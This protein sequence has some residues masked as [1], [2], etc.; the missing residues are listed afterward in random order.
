MSDE[1]AGE[2]DDA[3]ARVCDGGLSEPQR[4]ALMA[5]LR[6]SK[7]ARE[8]YIRHVSLHFWLRAILHREEDA[9]DEQAGGVASTRATEGGGWFHATW[10]ASVTAA[11]AIGASLLLLGL[12][13]RR[14]GSRVPPPIAGIVVGGVDCRWSS[15]DRLAVG[16]TIRSGDLISLESGTVSLLF[17]SRTRVVAPGPVSFRVVSATECDLRHGELVARVLKGG[18]GFRVTAGTL[19]VIDRG[20]AFGV[21]RVS[22]ADVEVE[23]FEGEV[24]L[25]D[26][27]VASAADIGDEAPLLR[28]GQTA[29]VTLGTHATTQVIRVG[30]GLSAAF[31]TAVG[32]ESEAEGGQRVD[33]IFEGFSQAGPE[34]RIDKAVGGAGWTTPW[35]DSHE[36]TDTANWAVADGVAINDR[37]GAG[38]AI[39]GVSLKVGPSE[40]VYASATLRLATA[41]PASPSLVWLTLFQAAARQGDPGKST[42]RAGFGIAARE[43][44]C[45]FGSTDAPVG[46]FRNDRPRGGFASYRTGEPTRMI[47][48][49]EI[50]AAGP[51]DRL[52]VWIDPPRGAREADAPPAGVAMG[53]L[54][55]GAIDKIALRFSCHG[56]ATKASVDD[57]RLGRSWNSVAD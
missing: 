30:A 18:R 27:L 24:E 8:A 50:D 16:D 45:G 29:A 40:P 20:T 57:V 52:S 31:A 39:R 4:L 22:A 51:A 46:R 9:D 13:A 37:T 23:V 54:D 17:D 42:L 26:S 15:D 44:F 14:G 35:S 56:D 3:L 28:E 12:F 21:R 36:R 38:G 47:G 10:W 19:H 48:K 33:A 6:Q 11:V 5:A 2:I 34:G 1:V 32:E 7:A 41:D 53:S 49:I 55:G 43:Y 25:C